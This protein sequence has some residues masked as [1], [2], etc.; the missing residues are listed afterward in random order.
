MWDIERLAPDARDLAE[1][2]AAEAGWPLTEWLAT[3]I[4]EAAASELGDLPEEASPKDKAA[5]LRYA[6]HL[7]TSR[8]RLGKFRSRPSPE[9]EPPEALVESIAVSGIEEPLVLRRDPEDPEGY[10]IVAGA[11]RWKAAVQLDLGDVPAV[12]STLN[13]AD[14]LL[15]SVAENLDKDD[16]TPL[17]EAEVYLRLLTALSVPPAKLAAAIG[18]DLASIAL[19]LRVLALPAPVKHA[20]EDER[21]GRQD[22]T[23]LMQA[24]DP[25]ALAARLIDERTEIDEEGDESAGL[26]EEID[27]IAKSAAKASG[28]PV[29]DWIDRAIRQGVPPP[30]S[31]PPREA[32]VPIEQSLSALINAARRHAGLRIAPG[33]DE[34]RE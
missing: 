23:G 30:P 9:P 8:L 31:P 33:P 15:V 17:Q 32:E 27:R 7:P 4:R 3:R 25:I 11:R 6:T 13:D 29:A 20:I 28:L 12:V 19:T 18:R 26:P 22:V 10:E 24:Q 14:A 34:P 16:F 5:L 21:L 1:A 2:A